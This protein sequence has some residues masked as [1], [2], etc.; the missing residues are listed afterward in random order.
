MF[1]DATY[2]TSFIFALSLHLVLVLFLF[3]RFT[4]TTSQVG[5]V[6]S[7]DIINAVAINERDFDHEIN[8]RVAMPENLPKKEV[9]SQPVVKKLEKPLAKTAE[10]TAITSQIQ[11]L[12]KK[13][14]LQEQGR[15]LAELKKEREQRKKKAIEQK[16]QAL[17]RALQEQAASPKQLGDL[18]GSGSV[19]HGSRLSGEVDKYKALIKQAI[20]LQWFQPEGI[21]SG[22]FCR[23]YVTIAPGGTV[24]DVKL[25]A[26]SGNVILERSAKAAIFKASPLPV[27][28]EPELFDEV[29]GIN[30]V[31]RPEG[32]GG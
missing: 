3:V 17:Q 9:V 4:H 16:E 32:I 22:D 8:K 29:R 7:R 18:D 21:T 19:A 27:P 23:L 28:E 1:N 26:S 5:L 11:D 13:N 6:A 10:K 30:L 15:E 20:Y 14:L 24:L 12:L 31:F 25:L 2:K